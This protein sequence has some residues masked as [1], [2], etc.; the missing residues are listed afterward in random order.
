MEK[1]GLDTCIEF[2]Y[3]WCMRSFS[4]C[5]FCDHVIEDGHKESGFTGIGPDWM[6][7]GD[8]GCD[9]NPLSGDDGVAQHATQAEVNEFLKLA[10]QSPGFDTQVRER[11]YA[12]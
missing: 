1:L 4:V 6:V 2:W 7:D 8:F 9:K 5:A 11:L 12:K 3:N 10:F